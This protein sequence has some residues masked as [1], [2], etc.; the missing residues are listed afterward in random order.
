MTCVKYLQQQNLATKILLWI[1]DACIKAI[2]NKDTAFGFT[3][4]ASKSFLTNILLL[5]LRRLHLNKDTA[6]GFTTLASKSFL[7]KIL[8]LDLQRLHQSHS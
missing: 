1:Y 3:T 6:F 5:D 2:L 8:L 4:L 7:T